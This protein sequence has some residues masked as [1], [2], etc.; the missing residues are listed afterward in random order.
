MA[1]QVKNP[2]AVQETQE[3]RVWSLGQED[4]LEEGM[5]THSTILA[6]EIRRTEEPGYSPRGHKEL[7]KTDWLKF[8]FFFFLR[9]L[10]ARNG[11]YISE[12]L[13]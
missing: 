13:E 12:W 9:V 1:Q 5:V 4:P 2:P 10:P 6:W 3:T 11:F 7:D 8:L